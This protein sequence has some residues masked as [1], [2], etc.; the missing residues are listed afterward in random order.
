[1]QRIRLV[2]ALSLLLGPRAAEA[3]QPEVPACCSERSLSGLNRSH[4]LAAD[5]AVGTTET[6]VRPDRRCA[7]VGRKNVRSGVILTR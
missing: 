4:E 7:A 6:R 5:G 3:Q 1:M 2:L